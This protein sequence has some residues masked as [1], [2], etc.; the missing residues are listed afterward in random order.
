MTQPPPIKPFLKDLVEQ[1]RYQATLI[2][3]NSEKRSRKE[4]DQISKQERHSICYEG[5]IQHWFNSLAP[6]DKCRVFRM[7]EFVN[8]FPG[9]YNAK[10]SPVLIG[11]ALRVLGWTEY[12]SWKKESRNTRG[13]KAPK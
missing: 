2:S 1:L 8:R 11:K 3:E 4:R 9:R 10:A 6:E 5:L 12:R 13:W 7:D